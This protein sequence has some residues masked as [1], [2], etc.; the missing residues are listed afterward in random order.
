MSISS[1]LL[2]L[3]SFMKEHRIDAFIIPSSDPHMSEYVADH[4]KNREWIS[5]FTGSAGTVLV[6]QNYAGL[7]TD[8]RYFIQAIQELEG[9]EIELNKI[10]DRTSLGYTQWILKNL[11]DRSTV[12]VNG[13]LFSETGV[14]RMEAKFKEKNIKL[15]TTLEPFQEIWQERKILPS[16]KIFELPIKFS[17]RSFQ[18]KLTDLHKH[19]FINKSDSALFTALDEIAWF[20][21]IRSNDIDY[22]P[23]PICY[24]LITT[25]DNILFIDEKKVDNCHQYLNE[26]KIQIKPYENIVDYLVSHN[27]KILVDP[28][29]C[30]T[31]LYR[32]LDSKLIKEKSSFIIHEKAIKNSIEL[33]GFRN[34]MIKDGVALCHAYYWLEKNINKGISEYEF[35]HKIAEFRSQQND[36]F[37]ESFNPIVGN[38]GN[39]AIIHYRADK[40][41]CSTI[42]PD[43]YLLCDSGAQ[44]MDGT[45]DITRSFAFGSPSDEYCKAYTLV[46]A[47]HINLALASY[48]EGT[49]GV[50][51]D[52]LARKA[53]WEHSMDFPHGTGH[54]VGSFL[55]VH[56]EPQGFAPGN[57]TRGNTAFKP[58]MVTSNEPGYYKLEKF[59]IRIENLIISHD[60][61]NGFLN[62]ETITLYP[63][64]TKPI[65]RDLLS[66]HQI[67]WL[68]DYHKLVWEKLSPHLD[69]DL[70]DWLYPQ[71]KGL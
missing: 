14:R 40:S 26:N 1:R 43:G 45:T 25:E 19:L 44:F 52:L 69:K 21:N 68:N 60:K 24:L 58:G 35:G 38:N 71:C 28:N 13:F 32:A 22:N 46:L 9:T 49:K 66:E 36:Y 48:P 20:L 10:I 15:I 34:A 16:E 11:P 54:G 12:G 47:G 8:S 67:Q 56:E 41:N 18:D 51:L 29:T 39:G 65:V 62:H 55:N 27:R 33:E 31:K 6:S 63:I 30:S 50:Q 5:G 7:W 37:G 70:Q 17:G 64:Q 61:G 4:W 2:S 42:L 23:V 57:S 53:L 59:G 3:R